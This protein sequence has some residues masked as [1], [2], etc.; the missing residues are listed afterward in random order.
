M[1][2][3]T[4][5]FGGIDY[6]KSDVITIPKGLLGFDDLIKF[7]LVDHIEYQ[8]FRWLQSIE[9][10]ELALLIASPDIVNNG[11]SD[12]LVKK[13]VGHK[14]LERDGNYDIFI[15]VIIP[16]GKPQAIYAN[17]KAPI[18]INSNNNVGVQ[19]VL[20]NNEYEIDYPIYD[21]LLT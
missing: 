4:D 21:K 9:Q 11:F 12:E 5:K 15:P 7:V 3:A 10:S 17:M 16:S 6:D 8:P 1:K 14:E 19:I 20:G 13:L 2:L 18:F